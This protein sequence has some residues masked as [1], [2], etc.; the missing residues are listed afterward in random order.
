MTPLLA[1]LGR[2]AVSTLELFARSGAYLLGGFLLAGLVHAA[3]RGRDFGRS[4]GT[5]GI[6]SILSA[7]GVGI[8]LPVCSC[9]VLPLAIGLRKRKASPE[10]VAAFTVATPDNS[11][12]TV[13]LTAG[14]FGPLFAAVRVVAGLLAAVLAGFLVLASEAWGEPE[15]PDAAADEEAGDGCET[16]RRDPRWVLAI[17][18]RLSSLWSSFRARPAPPAEAAPSPPDEPVAAAPG[19]L[20]SHPG[21][22]TP[23]PERGRVRSFLSE[24]WRF[25]FREVL[26]EVS[27]PLVA[28]LLLSGILS[29]ALPDDVSALVPGGVVGQILLA[30]A[31]AVPL[32]LCAS[33]STPLGAVLLAKGF[34]PA[35]VLVL[36]LT[37]PVT[38]A[39][40]VLL[41]RRHFGRRFV[42]SLFLATFVVA[43]AVG[44]AFDAAGGRAVPGSDAASALEGGVAGWEVA[45]SLAFAVPLLLSLARVGFRE[46]RRQVAASFRGLLPQGV[47]SRLDRVR[48]RFLAVSPRRL[49]TAAAILLALAWLARGLSLV[50]QG[51]VGFASVLGRVS[52]SPLAPGL[53][54]SPPAPFGSVRIV[55]AL[56]LRRLDIGFRASGLPDPDAEDWTFA[57]GTWHA[58]YTS[59][60][61]DPVESSYVTGDGNLLEAKVTLHLL[62]RDPRSF[63]YGLSSGPDAVREAALA[64]L[65]VLVASRPIEGLL[66]GGRGE[67]EREARGLLAARLDEASL[68]VEVVS[69][70]VLDLHP[71]LGA[72]G[73]F[74]DVGSAAED[75]ERRIY[76]A[77][78]VLESALPGA[79]GEASRIRASAAGEAVEKRE[80]S[81]ASRDAFRLEA[82]AAKDAPGAFRARRWWETVERTLAGRRL[83]VAPGR[84]KQDL[85]DA[86]GISGKDVP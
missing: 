68:P 78:A 18:S 75:R 46:G 64:V 79:R 28:G 72:V 30:A 66:T 32:Y 69:L 52:S 56:R 12:D 34:S 61:D 10:A 14:L 20:P 83:V 19:S 86:G 33:A 60:G 41:L 21:E 57:G 54:W 76:E 58:A 62:V 25:G 59:P 17:G 63:E 43:A 4:L 84:L 74:R 85:I 82:E 50:P 1:G 44:L 49:T 53:H 80:A 23:A 40:S 71:P 51:S 42:L 55:D 13:L 81:L 31:L 24:A 5:R 39:P 15:V 37:G 2:A 45:A 27:W 47:L 48:A 73:A 36:F 7:I 9:G 11:E 16:P 29:A 65:R 8:V 70:N 6:R 35:A 38:N 67:L 77:R 22:A 3:M 26:D